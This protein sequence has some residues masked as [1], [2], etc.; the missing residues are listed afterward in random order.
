MFNRPNAPVNIEIEL[1]MKAE[2]ANRF[3]DNFQQMAMIPHKFD[4]GEDRKILVFAKGQE[5]LNEA[6]QCGATLVGGAELVKEIQNGNLVISEYQY[7]IAHPNILPDIVTLRGIMKK[8]FPNPKNGTLG[9]N[10]GELVKR[11]L[12]GVQYNANKDE[13]QQD[14]GLIQTTIGTVS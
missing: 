12:N 14:F 5:L 10:V 1:N 11:F 9:P 8:K 7:F 6:Q 2:K 3:I 13:E 4:H